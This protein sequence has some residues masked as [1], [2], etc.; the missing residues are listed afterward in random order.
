M[1]RLIVEREKVIE[2]AKKMPP[3]KLASWYEYGLFIQSRYEIRDDEPMILD[4]ETRAWHDADLSKLG[5][6][7]PYDWGDTDPLTIGEPL[8]LGKQ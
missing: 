7:E 1:E 8:R 6:Y 4:E 5:E 3:E 2:L